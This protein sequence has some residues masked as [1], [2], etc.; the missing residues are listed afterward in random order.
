MFIRGAVVIAV[1]DA[2]ANIVLCNAAAIVAGELRV[3]VTWPEQ[4][5]DLVTVVPAVIIVVTA[6]VIGHT[7]TIATSKNCRLTCVEGC[8]S[9]SKT[10]ERTSHS[11]KTAD[12]LMKIILPDKA[13]KDD[14]NCGT[15]CKEAHRFT[16]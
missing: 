5:A 7:S 8:G 12:I 3:R 1:V 2:I 6:V 9:E 13:I 15:A 4:T 10:G 11:R 16:S 14:S